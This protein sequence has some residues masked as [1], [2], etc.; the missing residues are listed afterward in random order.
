MRNCNVIH[1]ARIELLGVEATDERVSLL[2]ASGALATKAAI[3]RV[4]GK[5]TNFGNIISSAGSSSGREVTRLDIGCGNARA[6]SG[7]ILGLLGAREAAALAP[8]EQAISFAVGCAVLA[9][10][11]V[12]IS[13]VM[14]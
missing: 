7:I 1:Q 10:L 14:R 3:R 9:S 6:G 13:A 8:A 2:A 11:S 4:L 5:R 12:A